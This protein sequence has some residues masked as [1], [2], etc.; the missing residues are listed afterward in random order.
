VNDTYSESKRRISVGEKKKPV[1]V[2]PW[3][4]SSS[5]RA[6]SSKTVMARSPARVCVPPEKL[7]RMRP[8]VN[9]W[10]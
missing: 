8:A 1:G 9:G 6:M 5:P 7:S 4:N 2:M 10:L 3:T